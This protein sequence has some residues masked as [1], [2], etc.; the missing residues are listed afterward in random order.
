MKNRFVATPIQQSTESDNRIE[1]QHVQ[2]MQDSSGFFTPFSA[3]IP[4]ATEFNDPNIDTLLAQRGLHLIACQDGHLCL[5]SSL[6]AHSEVA[7]HQITSTSLATDRSIS[8]ADIRLVDFQNYITLQNSLTLETPHSWTGTNI[9]GMLRIDD[10]L[11][12][13]PSLV[14]TTLNIPYDPQNTDFAEHYLIPLA[15]TLRETATHTDYAIV[16]NP[17]EQ[18]HASIAIWTKIARHAET[19]ATQ[20]WAAQFLCELCHNPDNIPLLPSSAV[21]DVWLHLARHSNADTVADLAY[22]LS[23]L[24]Q[25]DKALFATAETIDKVVSLVNYNRADTAKDLSYAMDALISENNEV[26]ITSAIFDAW[27]L[28]AAHNNEDTYMSLATLLFKLGHETDT[29]LSEANTI[30]VHNAWITFAQSATANDNTHLMQ[31]LCY[32]FT[33]VEQ[34][35]VSTQTFETS[36]VHDIWVHFVNAILSAPEQIDVDGFEL[37]QLGGMLKSLTQTDTGKILFGTDEV[38]DAW[39]RL[40][41]CTARSDSTKR[42]LQ[43]SLY[44]ALTQLTTLNTN[45]TRFGTKKVYDALILVAA[46][47]TEAA[48]GDDAEASFVQALDQLTS[49][50]DNKALFSTQEVHNILDGLSETDATIIAQLKEKLPIHVLGKRTR[51]DI[52]MGS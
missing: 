13:K 10:F 3:Q 49:S 20:Q 43:I 44:N 21:R 15:E 5:P 9:Q 17:E 35:T 47:L 39:I 25:A 32:A 34:C 12:A 51:D 14:S 23:K 26:L 11:L 42:D 4:T 22:S 52:R 8:L 1:I 6:L 36:K 16:F 31:E 37:I 48:Y 33:A 29:G 38:R 24:T 50:D 7:K 30:A 45:K 41:S 2:I 28:L 27:I 46:N 40:S 19:H 18:A